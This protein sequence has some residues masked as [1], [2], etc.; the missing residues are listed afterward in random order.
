MPASHTA[1][2]PFVKKL[3]FQ[4]MDLDEDGFLSVMV[5]I[6]STYLLLYDQRGTFILSSSLDPMLP[7]SYTNL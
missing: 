5:S 2:S 4:V 1:Y 6:F 3:E 7:Y